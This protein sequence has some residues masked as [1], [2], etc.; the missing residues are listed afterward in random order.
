MTPYESDGPSSPLF[1]PLRLEGN[2]TWEQL[3]C[4][5]LSE[6]MA[7]ALANAPQGTGISW[8]IPFSIEHPIL[9]TTQQYTSRIEPCRARWLVFMHTS[10]L[11]ALPTDAHGLIHP[12]RGQGMLNEHAATYV[13]LY[14]DGTEVRA[15]VRRRHQI[16][17]FQRIWGENCFQAVA[18]HKPFPVRAAHEQLRP[19]WGHSQTRVA[20]P[21]AGPWINWLWAWENPRPEAT[22]VGLRLEPVSGVVLVSALSA[23]DVVEHPLRWRARRKALLTLPAG[24]PFQPE[25]DEHGCLAQLQ[26][27]LGQVIS[28]QRRLQYPQADWETSYNNQL[29]LRSEREII[30]EYT[31]HPEACFHL[32][33]SGHSAPEVIPVARVEGQLSGATLK[34]IPPA[35][36]A[37]LSVPQALWCR[38]SSTFTARQASIW[39]HW[40]DTGS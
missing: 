39:R 32:T 22:I 12:M 40:T 11:R 38:S 7:Q 2:V 13:V 26:L 16:G 33:T 35:R 19:D 1:R 15:E 9:L 34:P 18:H 27:D 8:G 23:G 36:C 14:E 17:S 31:S 10:D 6:G 28:A 25:L 4:P 5:P 3:T 29:P 37:L 24:Q 30:V 20:Q 21:D